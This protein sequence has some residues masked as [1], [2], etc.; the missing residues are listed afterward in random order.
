MGPTCSIAFENEPAEPGSHQNHPGNRNG[1]F[2]SARELGRSL[3]QGLFISGLILYLYHSDLQAGLPEEVIRTRAFSLLVFCNILLT[4]VNRSFVQ[5][6]WKTLF[7]PNRILWLMLALTF[8]FLLLSIYQPVLR[9]LFGFARLEWQELAF[10]L[11]AA[12]PAVLWV[13]LLKWYR[14][15]L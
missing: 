9:Q 3:L 12:M 15:R 11:L 4:L 1:G 5:Q 6:F 10:C 14:R 13:E 7:I 2:F 8:G